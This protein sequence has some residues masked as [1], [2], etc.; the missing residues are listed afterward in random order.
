MVS[1]VPLVTDK[2]VSAQ[3]WS[4]Y[5]RPKK[6]LK[7]KI[8]IFSKP[9]LKG[10]CH[11]IIFTKFFH[12]SYPSCLT[13]GALPCVIQLKRKLAGVGYTGESGPLGVAYAGESGLTGVGYAGKFGLR[14]VAYTGEYR[15]SVWPTQWT[16]QK[17][18]SQKLTAVAYTG[19]SGLTG[20]GYTGESGITSVGYTGESRLTGVAYTGESLVQSSIF[21]ALK[22]TIP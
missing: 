12:R 8:S 1:P 18:F 13:R 17:K 20:V 22:G 5:I 2:S 14:G 11:E 4:F 9:I 6:S 7:F 16:P 21:N 10:Q 15:L 19:E 3:L